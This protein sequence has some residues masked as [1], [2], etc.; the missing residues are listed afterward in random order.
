MINIYYA[1]FV[2][3]LVAPSVCFPDSS[4]ESYGELMDIMT[5]EHREGVY[6]DYLEAIEDDY[7]EAKSGDPGAMYRLYKNFNLLANIYGI[8]GA[9]GYSIAWLR[10]AAGLKYPDA[11]KDLG[12]IYKNGYE[13]VGIEKDLVKAASYFKEAWEGGDMSAKSEYNYIVECEIPDEKAWD[14]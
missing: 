6:S 14:C 13:T 7:P 5:S 12:Y 8:Q 4:E 2:A 9:R 10:R 3:F 1:V 11:L